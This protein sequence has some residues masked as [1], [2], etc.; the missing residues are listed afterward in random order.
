LL[1]LSLCPAIQ[2]PRYTLPLCQCTANIA[3]LPHSVTAAAVVT[4]SC[5]VLSCSKVTSI[6][7][8]VI[9]FGGIQ[10]WQV[11]GFGSSLLPLL[12]TCWAWGYGLPFLS[13]PHF[14]AS[15]VWQPASQ[16]PGT[17]AWPPS[18]SSCTS[19]FLWPHTLLHLILF[20]LVYSGKPAVPYVWQYRRRAHS[21]VH[22][23]A[24]LSDKQA[25]CQIICQWSGPSGGARL[26]LGILAGS[27]YC[28]RKIVVSSSS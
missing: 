11:S 12:V 2:F 25:G 17:A 9:G 1:F 10:G 27:R 8:Y 13:H 14:I 21:L 18:S 20:L 22:Q 19:R 4:C 26:I 16:P 3:V 6:L 28:V 15:W 7:Y 23:T 24:Y 5:L